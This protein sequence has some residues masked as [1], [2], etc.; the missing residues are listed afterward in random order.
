MCLKSRTYVSALTLS[1]LHYP[2]R[3]IECSHFYSALSKQ[4]WNEF[5]VWRFFGVLFFCRFPPGGKRPIYL[6][7]ILIYIN[8]HI[9][10]YFTFVERVGL[11]LPCPPIPPLPLRRQD[12]ESVH[13][14]HSNF[15]FQRTRKVH[16]LDSEQLVNWGGRFDACEVWWRLGFDACEVWWQLGFDACEVWW[17]LGSMPVRCDGG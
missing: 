2:Y 17:R 13:G 15:R 4:P 11:K 12:L 16:S 14:P 7:N 6:L 1:A 3:L 5:A 8:L 9:Q 10:Y